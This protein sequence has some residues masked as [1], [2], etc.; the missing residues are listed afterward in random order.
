MACESLS[1][2][3][4]RL[5]ADACGEMIACNDT[6]P[7]GDDSVSVLCD[8]RFVSDEDDGIAA[9]V[10]LVEES[11]DL[12]ASLGVKVT[13]GFVGEDDR[14]LIHQGAGNRNALTLAA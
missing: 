14:G 12:V 9:R 4:L 10:E 6:V 2:L 8:V 13:G 7:D 5:V 11:H 1:Q 3:I